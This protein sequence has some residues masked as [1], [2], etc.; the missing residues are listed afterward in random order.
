M[1]EKIETA[2]TIRLSVESLRTIAMR[3]PDPKLAAEL[4]RIAAEMDEHAAELER[5]FVN[6]HSNPPSGAVS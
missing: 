3:E 4:M 6:Q 2:R 1:T 5:S